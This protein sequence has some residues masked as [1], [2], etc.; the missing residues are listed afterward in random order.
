MIIPEYTMLSGVFLSPDPM[1]G[2]KSNIPD[3]EHEIDS[4]LSDYVRSYRIDDNSVAQFEKAIAIANTLLILGQLLMLLSPIVLIII[5]SI[6]NIDLQNIKEADR[7]YALVSL[8]IGLIVIPGIFLFLGGFIQKRAKK[9]DVGEDYW[10]YHKIAVAIESYQHGD[11]DSV[12]N[13]LNV[14]TIS[15]LTIFGSAPIPFPST[16]IGNSGL[17]RKTNK[18]LKEYI[19]KLERAENKEQT[20]KESFTDFILPVTYEIDSVNP[21]E[22]ESLIE[23]IGKRSS[24]EPSYWETLTDLVGFGEGAVG[25]LLFISMVIAISLIG[26]GVFTY[27][28]DTLGM[29]VTMILFTSYQIYNTRRST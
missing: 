10:A 16:G 3:E 13:N 21:E 25:N 2:A 29:L 14:I 24:V 4:Q 20:I 19:G 6:F 18:Y 7:I 15:I 22:V 28:D 17:T 9:Y 5:T 12:Y 11:Y 23:N 26:F 1:D 8:I 27:I